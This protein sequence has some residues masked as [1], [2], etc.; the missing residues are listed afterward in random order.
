MHYLSMYA[1]LEYSEESAVIIV[2]CAFGALSIKSVSR[3]QLASAGRF[4][5]K[6]EQR[7]WITKADKQQLI[8]VLAPCFVDS[9]VVVVKEG[10]DINNLS[11]SDV[12]KV[13][14]F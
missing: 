9:G 4:F 6:G 11:T 14:T 13:G 5:L 2:M 12:V 8:N 10:A 7:K 1:S 3:S